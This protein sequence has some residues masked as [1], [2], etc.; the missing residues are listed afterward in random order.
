[1]NIS[2][3]NP[4]KVSGVLTLTIEKEDYQGDVEKT[5]KD[6]RKKANIPGFRVGQAP[7]GLIKR[8]FGASVKADTINKI[9]SEKLNGYITDNKLNMLG[10]P[11]ANEKQVPQDL[12]TDGPF[13][14]IFDI[15]VAP[16][17]NIEL[18]GD[19]TIDY[20]DID[21]DDKLVSQ[22]V[23]MF[24]S[25]AGHYDKV[26]EYD[27]AQNDMLKGDL[28]ELDADGNAKED[29]IVVE[30]AVLMP[31]YIKVDDQRKLFD[32][33]KLGSVIT[34]NPKKA[35]PENNAEIK[36]LL[37][38]DDAKAEELT[39]DFTFLVTEISRYIKAEVNQELFD[40][41]YGK[42]TV[43]DEADFRQKIQD[44][45]KAQ[46]V[47]DTDYKFLLD[48]RA[49]AENKV[50][51]LTFPDALLKR[52]MLNNNK[53][54]GEDFVNEHYD[55]SVK[56]LKWSLIKNQLVKAAGFKIEDADIKSVAKEAAR[57][58]FAQYGMTN[59]PEEYL[60]KYANDM[61]KNEKYIDNL[62]ERAIDVKLVDSL[63][64]IVKLNKKTVS[65]E[66]FNKMMQEK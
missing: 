16:E 27:A 28:R 50:G 46:L 63:K 6:Y 65:L 59:V 19:D 66:D 35:Y 21:V 5:L 14:F 54:K 51:E 12:E 34:F 24:Q 45:I 41:I 33:A 61:L 53:D 39:S 52:I 20:Y 29:G 30:A 55:A 4:D 17:F 9:I 3:E 26:E 44:G 38:I 36:S 56:E 32:G 58:Q 48:V 2:F 57:V 64:K 43:K 25:R 11:M 31:E 47:N 13:T 40:Q 42:D 23:E 10:E 62:V 60:E 15:A 8:Q 37:K 18:N 49:Y 1:M 7:M 22:Q